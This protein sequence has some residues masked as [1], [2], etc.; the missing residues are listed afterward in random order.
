MADLNALLKKAKRGA[1]GA[2][3]DCPWS[4][5]KL[6]PTAFGTSCREHGVDYTSSVGAVSV[7]VTQDPGSTTPE[8]TGRLCSV[9]N[10]CEPT[11]RTAQNGLSLW[12]VAVA[13]QQDGG[14]DPYL[15]GHYWTNAIMH[16]APKGFRSRIKQARTHCS[17]VL[18]D[19]IAALS[20]KV[21]IACG[22][23]ATNSLFDAGLLNQRWYQIRRSFSSGVYE[24]SSSSLGFETSV[25]CT[26]HMSQGAVNRAA[27]RL[28]SDHTE[29][30][31][32]QQLEQIEN[33]AV[34][35][36]FL[37]ANPLGSTSGKGMR[38]FLVHWLDIGDAIRRAHES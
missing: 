16:G 35:H 28:H 33:R 25:Y 3:Q 38:V 15:G 22:E 27:S 12:N 31:L 36:E 21:V 9:H 7:Q 2:C 19:Q 26:Y 11:D 8:K 34:V 37:K 17:S 13:R 29:E 20:P 4:P 24:A 5:V 18:R 23:H 10:S 1:L 32:S 14:S 30:L 6:G